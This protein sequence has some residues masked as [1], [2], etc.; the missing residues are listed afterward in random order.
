MRKSIAP[1]VALAGSLALTVVAAVSLQIN[2]RM[3]DRVRFGRAVGNA[4]EQIEARLDTHASIVRGV[5]ALISS[6]T[7]VQPEEFHTY[8]THLA[9]QEHNPGMQGVGF[10]QRFRRDEV[11]RVEAALRARGFPGLEIWPDAPGDERSAVVLLEPL[12]RRNRAAMGYDMLTH[13]VRRDAMERARD[14]GTAA[15]S[16]KVTLVQEIDAERQAGFLVYVPVY[17]GG[18]APSTVEARRAALIGWAYAPFRAGDFFTATF[19]GEPEPLVTFRIYDGPTPDP[20]R[21]MYD[22]R[23][24]A[25]PDEP[26]V[27]AAPIH[28]GGGEWTATFAALPGLRGDSFGPVIAALLIGSAIS[29]LVF[30]LSIGQSHARERAEDALAG[31]HRAVDEQRHYEERLR[32]ES[33]VNSILRRL[34]IALAAELDPD[35]L[36]QLIA[37]EATSLTGAEYGV[38]F[39]AAPEPRTL[40]SAG[41]G[42]DAMGQLSATR[43]A[44]ACAA[45]QPARIDSAADGEFGP[46]LVRSVLAVPINSRTG[47]PLGC[48]AFVHSQPD[49]FTPHHERLAAGIAGQA[50]IALDNARLLRDLQDADRRKDQFL[51]VLGHELR[52]PLAPVV[53]ALEIIKRDPPAAERQLAIVERQAR[54]MVRIVD[55]LLDVSRI[56]RGKIELQK[57]RVSVREA[58]ETAAES[59]AA[60]ARERAQK[61]TV[62]PPEAA[63]LI[64]ADP[65]RLDQILGNLLSNAIKYTPAGG[66]VELSAHERDGQLELRVRDTGIGFPPEALKTLFDPFV[67]VPGAKDYSTGGLGIGLSLVRGLVELHGGTVRAESPGPGQGATFTVVLPGTARG[68]TPSEIA[69]LAPRARRGRVLVVDDNVDA[70]ETLSEVVAME[71]HEVRTAHDGPAALEAAREMSPD[72]ILLD[73]GLPG[74]D[75]YEV[76]R[77]LRELPQAHDAFI[78]ALTGFGQQKD[79]ARALDAGFDQHLVKPV[80]LAT[81]TGVLRQQLGAAEAGHPGEASP[82]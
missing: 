40:A 20:A 58:L 53:T 2:G 33:R 24:A 23:L 55:E 49:R 59:V 42:E 19:Q 76:A 65:V 36:A 29:A 34:G 4:L 57:R 75:G 70:A 80:D 48:L 78:V 15:I 37:D 11:A 38:L 54:H 8:V 52:N 69:T 62:S 13:P 22:R 66:S 16:G 26:L 82:A 68:A 61:L 51:A 64:D 39:D 77:R 47:P 50:S 73:I 5:A 6:Q 30:L 81:V 12:D 17:A 63:L 60:M 71:G 18:E 1:W 45:G 32:E 7:G 74:M 43:L 10:A 67:Q 14:T 9:F 79:R 46:A 41:P 21:L 72:V 27:E 3:R 44:H 35:R 31:L 56:S 25:D 28:F